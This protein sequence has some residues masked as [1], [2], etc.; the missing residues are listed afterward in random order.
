SQNKAHQADA[1]STLAEVKNKLG[2]YN[3][4]NGN[5]PASQAELDTFIASS[6]GGNNTALSAKFVTAQGYT[7]A[8]NDGNGNS[9]DNSTTQCSGYTLTADKSIWSG[10]TN[11]VVTN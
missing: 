7:Y 5:Y 11:L 6:A 9:C 10:S 3:A 4:N 1:Q 2:E 8:P